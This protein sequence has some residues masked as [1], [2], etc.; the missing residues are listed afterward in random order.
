MYD[1]DNDFETFYT[2]V[3]NPSVSGLY[4]TYRGKKDL[5]HWK[6]DYCSNIEMASDGVKFPSFI[7]PNDSLKF[8][9]KSMCRPINLVSLRNLTVFIL[10][11]NFTLL[12]HYSLETMMSELMSAVYLAINIFSKKTL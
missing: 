6:G 5:P 2:G 9:R 10:C 12:V 7:Q 4:A 3:P 1:F 11:F 8:F